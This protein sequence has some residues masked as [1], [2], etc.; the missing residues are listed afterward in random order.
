MIRQPIVSV[1]G[2]VDHGKTSILDR[3]RGSAVVQKEAGGITQHIGATEISIEVL[4]KICGTSLDKK[5]IALTI[6]GLLF[7]DTPGHEAFTTLR[8]RGGAIADMAILV[9]DMNEG[10]MPQTDES[11]NFLKQF[12]TPFV[13]AATKID[14]LIGWVI[15]PNACFSKTYKEQPQRTQDEI[16]DK[17]YK[18]I[19]QLGERGFQAERFDRVKDFTKQ[20]GVVPVSGVT[21]EGI[22]DL[23]MMVAG[24]AQKYLHDRLGITPGEG[25]GTVLEVKEYRGMGTTIDVVIYDGEV[26]KGDYLV[27]GGEKTVTT[28]V[29]ALLE[30]APLKELRMEKDFISKDSVSAAA[31]VKI[32]A[33]DLEN[34]I[35]GSPLRAV[36]N[37]R[38]MDSAKREVVK[39]IA[40]VVIETDKEG[41]VLKADTLGSLEA[42]I[43][44]LKDAGLQIRKARVG[45]L[46]KSDVMEM[47]SLEEPMMFAFGLR[48][49]QDILKLAEDNNVKVFHS[50][51][52]YKLIEDHEEWEKEKRERREQMLL[53]KTTRPAKVKILS[54]CVFRQSKPAVF[55]I[56]VLKGTIKPGYTLKIKDKVIG[57]I[58]EIQSE[59][60]NVPEA[61]MGDKVALSMPGVVIGKH[62]DEGDVLETKLTKEDIQNLEKIKS[63]L[64]GDE[65]ELLEEE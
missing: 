19:G 9:V 49:P 11:L 5:G 39:E 2:H 3:I 21:G 31:G 28:R 41:V 1:L 62:A 38:D 10:F 35:A 58:K 13:V 15:E 47:R 61:K 20:V 29:K 40:E 33:P 55:G 12:K 43:K 54:G 14:K 56:E 7:I 25:K 22:P 64:R 24:I 34:V 53:E 44:S 32:A 18:I 51:V 45:N 65:V 63:K 23:L 30:P 60:E 6:P 42:L 50:N 16:E 27:I 8:K 48:P 26:N 4:R 52:I 46:T 57:E 59:G 37:K 36:K 17:I